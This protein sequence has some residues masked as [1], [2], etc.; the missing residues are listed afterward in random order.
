MTSPSSK[1]GWLGSEGRLR[2]VSWGA[3]VVTVVMDDDDEEE[4]E[5]AAVATWTAMEAETEVGEGR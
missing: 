3:V 4:E 2:K 5:E 1:Q